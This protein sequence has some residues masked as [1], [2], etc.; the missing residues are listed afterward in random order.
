MAALSGDASDA[1]L[2]RGLYS[3]EQVAASLQRCRNVAYN[4][5]IAMLGDTVI[6]S[7]ASGYAIGS[8]NWVI[9]TPGMRI[10]YIT[11]C[12]MYAPHA[13]DAPAKASLLCTQNGQCQTHVR[14]SALRAHSLSRGSGC[15]FVSCEGKQLICKPAPSTHGLDASSRCGCVSAYQPCAPPKKITK[16]HDQRSQVFSG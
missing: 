9:K 1:A 3:Q 5:K 16:R 6:T 7:H 2:W 11:V 14:A 12:H 10:S 13:V 4:E 15:A 8:C